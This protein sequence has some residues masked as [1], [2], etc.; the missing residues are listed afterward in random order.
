LRKF[1]R[2]LLFYHSVLCHPRHS[3]R[4]AFFCLS[5]SRLHQCLAEWLQKSFFCFDLCK[6]IFSYYD[7]NNNISSGNCFC[8]FFC[9]SQLNSRSLFLGLLNVLEN[10][11]FKKRQ[12]K[13][14]RRKNA[15]CET[16]EK[17]HNL[18]EFLRICPVVGD[19]DTSLTWTSPRKG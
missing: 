19:L 17:E 14:R 9:K 5:I 6:Q 4:R 12:H 10:T 3:R 15:S 16:A 18:A 8:M 2:Q 1:V 13:F 7:T 11:N